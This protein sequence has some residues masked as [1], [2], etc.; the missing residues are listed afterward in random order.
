MTAMRARV[1]IASAAIGLAAT[2]AVATLPASA[3]S[4]TGWQPLQSSSTTDVCGFAVQENITGSQKT[5]DWDFQPTYTR[6]SIA[7]LTLTNE[8]TGKRISFPLSW[9]SVNSASMAST[10]NTDTGKFVSSA[11]GKLQLVRGEESWSNTYHEVDTDEG[12]E[13]VFTVEPAIGRITDLCT[14]LD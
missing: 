6:T 14:L 2:S 3:S 13:Y 8:S 1:L 9:R 5:V 7:K 11:P 12:Y 10:A 4:T